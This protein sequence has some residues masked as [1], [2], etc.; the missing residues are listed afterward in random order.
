[1]FDSLWMLLSAPI[2]AEYESKVLTQFDSAFHVCNN[3]KTAAKSKK[4][5]LKHAL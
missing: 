4:F 1:M 2:S 5:G 3:I